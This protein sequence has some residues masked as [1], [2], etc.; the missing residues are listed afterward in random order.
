[1]ALAEAI[2]TWW[3]GEGTEKAAGMLF[4][5]QEEIDRGRGLDSKLDALNKSRL[6][7]GKISQEQWAAT[8]DRYKSGGFD[9]LLTNPDS[10]PWAG[11]QEGAVEGLANVQSGIKEAI[12]SPLRWSLGAIPWEVWVA[13][14]LFAAWKTGILTRLAARVK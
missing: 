14:L 13:V 5:D 12:R 9:T 8:N 10:S 2:K 3:R 1:M 4:L 11:F 7:D 6:N